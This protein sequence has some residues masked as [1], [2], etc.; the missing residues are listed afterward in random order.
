MPNPWMTSDDLLESVKRKI[1]FPS[2]QSTF[3]DAD[4]L[5]FANEE[6]MI[7]QVPSVMSFHEEYLSRSK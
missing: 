3:T 6:L 4:I 7:S 1:S 2:S 5:A